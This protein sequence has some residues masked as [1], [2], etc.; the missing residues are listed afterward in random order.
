[1]CY[2]AFFSGTSNLNAIYNKEIKE[3]KKIFIKSN[4]FDSIY[5]KKEAIILQTDKD[6]AQIEYTWVYKQ[7]DSAHIP[8][9]EKKETPEFIH[10]CKL[11]NEEEIKLLPNNSSFFRHVAY[12]NLMY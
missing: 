6:S 9:L 8:S 11:L 2:D 4:N 7:K 3:V 5:V 1:M 10:T 12:L